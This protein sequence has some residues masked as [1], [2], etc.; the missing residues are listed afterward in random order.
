MRHCF[1]CVVVG[2]L[3]LLFSLPAHA[4]SLNHPCV[5][6][7]NAAYAQHNVKKVR[8]MLDWLSQE[9][10]TQAPVSMLA[11]MDYFGPHVV[12]T[13]NNKVIARGLNALHTQ[14]L[15]MQ[16]KQNA[17]GY[18]L[19]EVVLGHTK[20]AIRFI[21]TVTSKRNQQHRFNVIAI[22]SFSRNKITAWNEVR[23]AALI[24]TPGSSSH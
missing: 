22:F 1:R 9:V 20:I 23:S 2:A 4:K 13:E 17:F 3:A 21:E 8:A 15:A 14:F 12:M 5:L 11:M 6:A 7:N 10:Q 18:T 19:K 24:G 16:K